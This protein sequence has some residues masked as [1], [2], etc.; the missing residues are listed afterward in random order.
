MQNYVEVIRV[1]GENRSE[2]VTALV[3]DEETNRK[4]RMIQEWAEKIADS[5][6]RLSDK[7]FW[8]LL[9]LAENKLNTRQNHRHFQEKVGPIGRPL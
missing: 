2:F 3:A 1:T 7:P 8:V 9:P 5:P 4:G 6:G